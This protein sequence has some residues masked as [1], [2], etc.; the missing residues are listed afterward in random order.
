VA[1]NS[2]SLAK[3]GSTFAGWNTANATTPKLDQTITFGALAG[4]TLGDAPFSL[5]A[6][7]SSGLTVSYE[8]SNTDVATISGNTVTLVAVGSATITLSPASATWVTGITP[9]SHTVAG[10]SLAPGSSQVIS[11]AVDST[12]LTPGQ[13]YNTNLVFTSND[14]SAPSRSVPFALTIVARPSDLATFRLATRV[15][16]ILRDPA[17]A[18]VASEE[19]SP[20]S[21]EIRVENP[22]LWWP[23]HE[24]AAA[25]PSAAT[26]RGIIPPDEIWPVRQ[27]S[28][29][30]TRHA[31]GSWKA[32][33]P[34]SWLYPEVF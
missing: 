7:A 20:G 23:R 4:K 32:D 31:F 34:N 6:T 3:T 29:W 9:A 8:S 14:A 33:E 13:T 30:T 19:G 18:V 22:E 12:G 16:W 1:A 5:D 11:V 17:G 25:P 26:L 28:A 24:G 27:T 10:D 2:G 15:R 21:L